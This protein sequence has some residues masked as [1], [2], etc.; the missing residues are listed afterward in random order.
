MIELYFPLNYL[1]VW[2][3]WLILLENKK[4]LLVWIL[5]SVFQEHLSSFD[6]KIRL[7]F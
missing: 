4:F 7:L 3:N 2:N 1:F 6:L 5:I